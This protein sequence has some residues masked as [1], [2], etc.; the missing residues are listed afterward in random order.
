MAAR[1]PAP[2]AP[3]V[4]SDL[5]ALQ[6]AW[7]SVAGT[8]Q[9]RLLVAGRKFCFEFSGGDIYIGTFDLGPAG[10]LD[11][12]VEEG[13]ADHRGT[14]PCLYQLD[15]GVLRWC[16]GRPRSGKRPSRFPDVDDSRYLSLVFRRAARRK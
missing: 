14:S 4:R 9:A 3:S 1:A 7:E 12:H 10:Q 15:G 5:D 6:G 8:R 13:P 2:A 16:P 11:M